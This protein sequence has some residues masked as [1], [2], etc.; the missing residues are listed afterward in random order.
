MTSEFCSENT[1]SPNQHEW[2]HSSR[3]GRTWC[4][5][6]GEPFA[7]PVE[8]RDGAQL[9]AIARSI[10]VR[11]DWHEP[12]EQEIAARVF[13]KSFDNAGKWPIDPDAGEYSAC[14]R[15]SEGLEMYV[16]LYKDGVPV[17]QVNLAT[18]FAMACGS[19]D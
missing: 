15:D 8:I 16:E 14:H 10:G 1:I 17:A 18:L 11:P 13:G 5:E 4:G 3:S 12:D 9:R 6:C 2:V 19:V 7:G